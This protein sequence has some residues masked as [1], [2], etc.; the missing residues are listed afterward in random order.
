MPQVLPMPAQMKPVPDAKHPVYILG[1]IPTFYDARH[2]LGRE[3][4]DTLQKKFE[5][6]CFPPVRANMKLREAP[7]AKQTIRVDFDK[8]D[9]LLN[10]VGELVLGRESL[11]GAGAALD[12]VARE[13]RVIAARAGFSLPDGKT[14][15][16]VEEDKIGKAHKSV[17]RTVRPGCERVMAAAQQIQFSGELRRQRIA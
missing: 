16:I 17:A 12:T 2:K 1:V 7:A 8:L 14:F 9:R 5:D 11:R 15:I 6:L 4:T 10:L 3:V 13:A